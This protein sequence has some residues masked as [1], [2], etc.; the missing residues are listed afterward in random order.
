M[1]YLSSAFPVSSSCF[2]PRLPS[3]PPPVPG[4]MGWGGGTGW[5]S[6]VES[7]LRTIVLP[8]RLPGS[9]WEAQIVPVFAPLK[10]PLGSL[11]AFLTNRVLLLV[12]F[13]LWNC[14]FN[15]AA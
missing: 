14:A 11:Y 6:L 7:A 5:G 4:R 9:S 15:H 10:Q 13:R 8:L 1:H 3:P 2:L 12:L